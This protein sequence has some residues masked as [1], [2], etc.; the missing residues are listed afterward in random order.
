MRVPGC[1]SE[2]SISAS[3]LAYF[4]MFINNMHVLL[5]RATL[6]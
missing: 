2:F 5:A 4:G 3:M 1:C 6:F